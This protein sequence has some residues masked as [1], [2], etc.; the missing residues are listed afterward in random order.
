MALATQHFIALAESS[1]LLRQFR[2]YT[3]GPSY[4]IHRQF[5]YYRGSESNRRLQNAIGPSTQHFVVDK[6]ALFLNNFASPSP[7]SC[8]SDFNNLSLRPSSLYKSDLTI[9]L[10]YR[11]PRIRATFLTVSLR[12]SSSYKSD[13]RPSIALAISIPYGD[14]PRQFHFDHLPRV[15]AT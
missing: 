12:P 2:Q 4:I 5:Y 13:F 15:R 9:S 6:E 1:P 3:I 8:K 10:R 14:F 11:L 7:S